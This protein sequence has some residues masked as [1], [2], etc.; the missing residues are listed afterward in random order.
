MGRT[1][2]S[3]CLLLLRSVPVTPCQ[4]S[5]PVPRYLPG[6][7]QSHTRKSHFPPDALEFTA[8]EITSDKFI[9]CCVSGSAWAFPST[10][11]KMVTFGEGCM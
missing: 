3:V 11:Q 8:Q 6:P 5:S 7:L 2:S 4:Q 1:S 10:G 9:L